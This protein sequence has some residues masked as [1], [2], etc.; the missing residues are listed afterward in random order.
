[1]ALAT[2]YFDESESGAAT[3]VAGFA[4][5]VE[6]WKSFDSAWN[7]MLD[8]YKVTCLHMKHYT[9]STGEFK[10]WKGDEDKRTRFM[11]RVVQIVSKKCMVSSVVLIDKT[12]FANTVAKDP[13]VSTFYVN[14]YSTA[15][16]M[17]LLAIDKWKRDC[18]FSEPVDYVFDRGNV[19]RSDFQRAYDIAL[20]IPEERKN[21]GA[22][23]FG[24]D[25]AICALQAAD[26]MAWETRKVYTD[27]QAGK[28]RFRKSLQSFLGTMCCDIKIASEANLRKLIDTL[29]SPQMGSEKA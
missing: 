29:R 8:T 23:A 18:G 21:L 20:M 10:S 19:R 22:L 28:D 7:K 12:A 6:R 17:S 25:Q 27:L 11:Q 2:A 4:A 3:V 15:A 1:M 14:E 9:Q 13:V 16:I 5:T 24:D 26:F